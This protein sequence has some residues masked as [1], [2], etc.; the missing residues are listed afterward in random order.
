MIPQFPQFKK[1]TL[2]D[3]S[4][5]ESITEKYEPYSDFNFVSV[6]SYNTTNSIKVSILNGNLVFLFSDYLTN[7]N[8]L[9]FIGS[10]DVL[11][12]IE[13]LLS[14]AHDNNL[15]TE[16]QM[17]PEVCVQNI[18]NTPHA[19]NVRE[20]ISHHDYIL[21]I[22]KIKTYAGNDFRAKRNFVNRF[23]KLYKEDAV[24]TQLDLN[25]WLVRRKILKVLKVWKKQTDQTKGE[26]ANEMVAIHRVLRYAKKID[27]FALGVFIKNKL[28][29]FSINELT[30]EKYGIIHYEKADK[31]FVGIFPFL[32][33]QTA[34]IL[35]ELG[36]S[37]INYEQDLGIEGL[38][39]AKKSYCPVG[40]LKKY[41]IS[42][43]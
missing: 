27:I 29:G 22:E 4:E 13:K 40:F 17:I 43:K 33:Q 41:T 2:K 23:V 25:K 10:G 15:L 12:T 31:D 18:L 37:F 3:K 28:V 20:E 14:Y 36:C 7:Q 30:H 5:V 26:I 8:F 19:F 21:D 32:K 35:S 16:L 39:K 24:V 11:D 38:R 42:R 9:T 34:I 1:L 6:W